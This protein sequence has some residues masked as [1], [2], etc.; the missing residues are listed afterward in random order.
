L[1]G[2]LFLNTFQPSGLPG[3]INFIDGTGK[4]Y[5]IEG[6]IGGSATYY[7]PQPTDKVTGSLR[8]SSLLYLFFGSMT[9]P[10]SD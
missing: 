3:P 6:E 9:G 2:I 8:T 7:I 5:V 4:Q 10:S 1:Q